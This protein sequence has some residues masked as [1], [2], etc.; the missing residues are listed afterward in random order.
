MA[1]S[2]RTIL[3]VVQRD[4]IGS[5][6]NSSGINSNYD[7]DTKNVIKA[8]IKMESKI[9][10][11]HKEILN[12]I[13]FNGYQPKVI[14]KVF[15]LERYAIDS[16]KEE[17]EDKNSKMKSPNFKITENVD[18]N[19]SGLLPSSEKMITPRIVQIVRENSNSNSYSLF[20]LILITLNMLLSIGILSTVFVLILY[21]QKYNIFSK[22][23]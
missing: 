20:S 5:N 23:L 9:D 4:S 10:E 13:V 2:P 7:D 14:D 12:N 17:E 3:K 18:D 6:I 19:I 22:S 1:Q 15:Y 8:F 16:V 11:E 21:I